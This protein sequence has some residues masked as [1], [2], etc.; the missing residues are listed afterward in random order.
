MPHNPRPPASE[1]VRLNIVL[2]EDWLD[3]ADVVLASLERAGLLIEN[4]S[5]GTG[6]VTGSIEPAHRD[7]ISG[8]AGI[9][10][11]EV[12]RTFRLPTPDSSIQ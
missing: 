4:V 12:D 7:R 1:R 5:V 3:R 10:A 11:V 6:V 2:A 8:L 9:A